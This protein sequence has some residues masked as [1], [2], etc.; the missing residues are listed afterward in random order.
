M[1]K[2]KH[3]AEGMGQIETERIRKLEG[4]RVRKNDK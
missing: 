2:E 1:R 4:E 3:R